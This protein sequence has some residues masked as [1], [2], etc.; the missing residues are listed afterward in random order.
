MNNWYQD[1]NKYIYSNFEHPELFIDLLAATSP[2]NHLKKNWNLALQLY[3]TRHNPDY[4]GVM[5]T[6]KSNVDRALRGEPLSGRK[7]TAFAAN[8]KGDYSQITIDVWTARYFGIEGYLSRKNFNR[9]TNIIK[10]MAE[11]AGIAP[12]IM[13]AELWI[14][15]LK[16][17]GRKPVS[18]LS[19]IDYQLKLF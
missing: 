11:L 7:I 5:R 3:N 6:Y 18:Y 10:A 12:A 14:R 9:I 4:S 2:R 8:L 1:I 15:S 16:Q 17:N 13:Q 19:V